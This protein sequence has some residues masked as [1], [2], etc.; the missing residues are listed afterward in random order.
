[1]T[2][3]S[4]DDDDDDDDND[5]D[6]D[7]DD[8]EENEGDGDGD[9][10]SDGDDEDPDH[11][12]DESGSKGMARDPSMRADAQ[13]ILTDEDF[14]L[15][16]KLK[17]ERKERM[18]GSK[19]KRRAEDYR[20]EEAR[21]SLDPAEAAIVDP[22]DLQG[23]RV[24]KRRSLEERLASVQEGRDGREVF[25]PHRKRGMSNREKAKR[26]KD[27]RMVSKKRSVPSQERLA[28]AQVKGRLT[29][30]LKNAKK[31]TKLLSKLRSRRQQGR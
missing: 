7:G 6:G 28:L 10:D 8:A 1:M 26:T 23:F 12:S 24:Q 25:A 17:A 19:R 11:G 14:V 2:V 20:T 30:H 18:S 3:S 5:D 27:Y 29:K 31:K 4:D 21:V 15:I 13:R 9:G 22:S 16:K